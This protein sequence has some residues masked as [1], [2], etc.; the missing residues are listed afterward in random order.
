MKK[1]RSP[2]YEMEKFFDEVFS[3]QPFK[4]TLAQEKWSPDVDIFETAEQLVIIMDLAGVNKEQI[5]VSFEDGLLSISGCRWDL[6]FG[7]KS[8]VYRM[9]IEYGDF[10]RC[11]KISDIFDPTKISARQE[12][13][14]L[15][16]EIPKT[17]PTKRL[18]DVE[19]K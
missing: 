10:E 1:R 14:L 16:I 2:F 5:K 15:I 8:R 18:I 11:F 9:E 3:Q 6:P 12:N 19:T 13:G 7:P 17:M 4:P